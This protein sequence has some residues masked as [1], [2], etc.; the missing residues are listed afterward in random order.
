MRDVIPYN[1]CWCMVEGLGEILVNSA[2]V[3]D[4]S[5]TSPVSLQ[6]YSKIPRMP[7]S[8]NTAPPRMCLCCA[9][10]PPKTAYE[11]ST[12]HSKNIGHQKHA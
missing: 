1:L 11:K 3:L 12:D 2:L 7:H 4:N 8:F 5:D 9:Q 6:K 10:E